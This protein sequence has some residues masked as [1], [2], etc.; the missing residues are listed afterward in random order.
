MA[1]GDHRVGLVVLVA[2]WAAL[3]CSAGK[4][5]TEPV[6]RLHDCG[7]SGWKGI[8]PASGMVA[9]FV[10]AV[11][12]SMDYGLDAVASG[13]PPHLRD[14][15]FQARF[16]G[17]THREPGLVSGMVRRTGSTQ[18]ATTAIIAPGTRGQPV[19]SIIT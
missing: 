15:R 1:G 3:G 4:L 5:A 6:R 12:H 9:L 16:P 13:A 11:V 10:T 14:A 18:A 7:Q 8:G 19:R 17:E 2:I